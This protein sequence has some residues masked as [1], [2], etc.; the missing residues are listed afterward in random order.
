MLIA[1]AR[2][3][4]ERSRRFLAQLCQHVRGP[5][6]ETKMRSRRGA[7]RVPA[8]ALIGVALLLGSCSGGGG[9]VQ[10][11]LR[12]WEVVP[13]ET[14][15]GSGEVT[16]EVS[17]DGD[18]PHE[19]VVLRTDVEAGDLPLA[20]DGSADEEGMEVVGEVEDLAAGASDTLTVDLE[21]G[22]YVLLCNILESEEAMEEM[23]MPTPSH[24]QNGMRTDFTV[25]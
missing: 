5:S 6:Y 24:Y 11:Q 14:S 25:E 18:E 21:P 9:T 15:V 23:D 2:V 8:S 22:H 13:D 4:T 12:E 7:R 19:F 10:V 16:F 17:N 3:E 20:D 1:E